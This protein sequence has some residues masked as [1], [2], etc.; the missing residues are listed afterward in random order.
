MQR[1]S[2]FTFFR[3]WLGSRGEGEG[4]LGAPHPTSAAEAGRQVA[5]PPRSKAETLWGFREGGQE[6]QPQMMLSRPQRSGQTDGILSLS[7]IIGVPSALSWKQVGVFTGGGG[8]LHWS[9]EEVLPPS[10][11]GREAPFPFGPFDPQSGD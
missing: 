3:G 1:E 5:G 11:Q 10:G 2:S 7:N 8:E 6:A 4:Q 9:S